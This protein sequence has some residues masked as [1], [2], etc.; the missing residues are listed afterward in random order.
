MEDVQNL[1]NEIEAGVASGLISSEEATQLSKDLQ[2]MSEAADASNNIVLK[3]K[4]L[5]TLSVL[6]KVV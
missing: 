6:S 5:T 2:N 1:L 3:G 4:I